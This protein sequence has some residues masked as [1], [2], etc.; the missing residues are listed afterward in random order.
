MPPAGKKEEV[1]V[2]DDLI[3]DGNSLHT[4]PLLED[5]FEG[6]PVENAWLFYPGGNIGSYCPYQ[7]GAL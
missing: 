1:W 6:G 4:P 2:I 7:K 5:S 3:V